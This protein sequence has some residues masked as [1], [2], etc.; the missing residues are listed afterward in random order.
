[1]GVEPRLE[2]LPHMSHGR[3]ESSFGLRAGPRTVVSCLRIVAEGRH[4]GRRFQREQTLL[5]LGIIVKSF[6]AGGS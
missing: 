2:P 3:A 4:P 6:S 1:M 5:W